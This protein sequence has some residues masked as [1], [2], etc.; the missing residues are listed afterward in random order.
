MS[1]EEKKEESA[2]EQPEPLLEYICHPAKRNRR[3]TVLTTMVI[4]VCIVLTYFIT[5]SAFMTILAG[6]ILFGA[7]AQFYFPTRYIFF[8]HAVHIKTTTQTLKKEWSLYRSYYADKNGVLLSPFGRP[9]R[10]E[11]FRGQY[12]RF[13]GNRD[14]VMNIVK[15]KINFE[16]FE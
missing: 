3:I 8:D 14:E 12:I 11:N 9:T 16:G 5:Y 10:L 2:V 15:S 1:D 7:L 4:I 6:V 13:S